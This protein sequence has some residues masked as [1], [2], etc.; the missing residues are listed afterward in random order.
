VGFHEEYD[1]KL[2]DRLIQV[3]N[4]DDLGTFD[5]LGDSDIEP[6]GWYA[7]SFH[8]SAALGGEELGNA[9]LDNGTYEPGNPDRMPV[10]LDMGMTLVSRDAFFGLIA[11]RLAELIRGPS[12]MSEEFLVRSLRD[13]TRRWLARLGDT[14]KWDN[15]V[16]LILSDRA[17]DDWRGRQPR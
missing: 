14:A 1:G 5:A 2:I 4:S 8:V 16:A 7:A 9:L 10:G 3:M 12:G 11:D 13:D 6:T 17:I 15:Q